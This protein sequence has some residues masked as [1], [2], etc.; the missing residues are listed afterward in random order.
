M[1][2]ILHIL[3]EQRVFELDRTF[4]YYYESD[5][6]I[7]KGTRALINFNGKELVGFVMEV[8]NYNEDLN[9]ITSKYPGI[10]QI[11]KIIDDVPVIDE[12]LFDLAQYMSKRYVCPLISCFQAILPKSL[13]PSTSSK[14]AAK[15]QYFSYFIFNKDVNKLTKRQSEV[16]EFIKENNKV[17]KSE[18][19]AGIAKKLFEL[20]AIREIKEEK[21][22]NID[23]NSGH[24]FKNC[25]LTPKQ[26]E[27]FEGI[28]KSENPTSLIYGVTGSGK[29]EIYIKLIEETIKSSRTAVFL[30]PE[31]NLTPHFCEK[32]IYHFGDQVSILTSGLTDTM[33]YREY[34]KILRGDSKVVIG[35]RSAIFAPLKN[36]GLIVIDEEFNENYKQDEENPQ[37]HAIDI[38]KYRCAK[39]NAKLALG[40]ATPSIDSMAR[41]LAGQYSLFKIEERYND[42]ELPNAKI[43][44][45]NNIDNLYPGYSFLSN[46]LVFAM[47]LAI[48]NNQKILL[49]L[50]R[51]GYS[52]VLVC[53]ECGQTLVCEKCK[54]P[55]TYHK[56][57][58]T[59]KCNS[60]QISRPA[61]S[62]SCSC[63]NPS[64]TSL[65]FGVEMLEN[66]LKSIFPNENILRLDGDIATKAKDISAIL[67]EYK[68]PENHIL[69]GTEMIAKGHDFS[70]ISVVGIINIDQLLSLP[71]YNVNERVFQ[72]ITQ[73]IGRAGR[74]DGNGHAYVQ[75]NI[76][77]SYAIN[78]GATQDY[79]LFYK[80]EMESRK[81]TANPPFFHVT[82]LTFSG[83][84]PQILRNFVYEINGKVR[85][86]LADYIETSYV[87]KISESK[88]FY[89][90]SVI[91]KYKKQSEILK[92]CRDFARNFKNRNQISLKINI[93]PYIF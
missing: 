25:E 56:K 40:S 27:I 76:M 29:T 39:N 82:S 78:I 36:I 52:T 84:D 86:E 83:K 57:S 15:P 79:D 62:I 48:F 91:I 34:R 11:I 10:K 26:N 80:K 50:N 69:I 89:S 81:N 77:D 19:P 49:L 31:I 67:N 47:K 59:Y 51:K 38:A 88:G 23:F 5:K 74:K 55:L 28:L 92:F 61:D 22:A 37:Y 7:Q 3:V 35:T 8:E 72:L 53:D 70:D 33:R 87:S 41:A 6:E 93:D 9:D 30:V 12:E 1:I 60:C 21:T 18:V 13:K 24:E 58:N 42:V 71:H 63:G 4:Y 43:I 32:L 20:D 65:G 17:L 14:N 44:N 54:H 2:F 64:F 16:L 75:T 73:C 85:C 66:A 90:L 68:K 46:E 45:M